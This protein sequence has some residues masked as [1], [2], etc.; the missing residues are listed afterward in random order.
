MAKIVENKKFV[1]LIAKTEK[2]KVYALGGKKLLCLSA[3]T[4]L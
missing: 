4:C 3:E 1:P 2:E